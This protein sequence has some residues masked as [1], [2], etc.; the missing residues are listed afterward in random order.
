MRFSRKT[1]S[2]KH[3]HWPYH[4]SNANLIIAVGNQPATF[5]YNFRTAIVTIGSNNVCN[6]AVLSI[7]ESDFRLT[8]EA[9]PFLG[10]HHHNIQGDTVIVVPKTSLIPGSGVS[11]FK[12]VVRSVYICIFAVAGEQ[13]GGIIN[14]PLNI[15]W[16]RL[17]FDNGRDLRH[18]STDVGM[19]PLSYCALDLD[20]LSSNVTRSVCYPLLFYLLWFGVFFLF[21][22][23]KFWVSLFSQ[24]K[25]K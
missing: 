12:G 24:R 13:A 14:R 1:Q 21:I 23:R 7:A 5:T 4:S 8:T 3:I 22:R 18:A 6:N 17:P 11:I 2:H 20:C 15:S 10:Q 19:Y 9:N 25:F 16:W